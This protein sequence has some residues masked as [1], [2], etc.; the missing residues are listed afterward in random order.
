MG[1]HGV[2][3]IG[4]GSTQ[5]CY[6]VMGV[7]CP[8]IVI[9]LCGYGQL[10]V[11]IREMGLVNALFIQGP[12]IRPIGCSDWPILICLRQV[13]NCLRA[14]HNPSLRQLSRRL[15]YISLLIIIKLSYARFYP[16][17]TS[18]GCNNKH[19]IPSNQESPQLLTIS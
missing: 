7:R 9:Y 14:P 3:R 16:R 4:V 1:V 18:L 6:V 12:I 10:V 19:V 2:L 17:D 13:L 5:S 11:V 8:V 15:C